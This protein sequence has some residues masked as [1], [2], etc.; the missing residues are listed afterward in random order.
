MPSGSRRSYAGYAGT[1]LFA[2]IAGALLAAAASPQDPAQ[3]RPTFRVGSSFVRVDAYPSKDGKAVPDLKAEEFEI[4][5]D[6]VPQKIESFERVEIRAGATDTEKR[7]VTS[8]RDS[9]Q[10]AANP[11]NRVFVIF[12][13]TPH[14]TLDVVRLNEALIRMLDRVLGPDDLVGVMSPKMSASQLVLGRK[15]QI[16]EQSLRSNSAFIEQLVYGKDPTEEGYEQCGDAR[17]IPRK[18]ERAT[19]EALQDLVRYLKTIR[20][21][22]KAIITVTGGWE[23]FREDR[24]ILDTKPRG[25]V[26]MDTPRTGPDGTL[27]TKPD[28]R[29]DNRGVPTRSACDADRIRL[30]TMDDEQFFR[31]L[32]ADANA[33]NASFYP[34]DPGGLGVFN[35]ALIP[36]AQ[37]KTLTGSMGVRQKRTDT[38]KTLAENTDGVALVDSNDLDG[39]L[40]RISDDLTSYYLLGYSSTNT[41]MDGR[42]R[43]LKVRVTRPGVIVRARRGYRGPT[44]EEMT[45][46]RN[47]AESMPEGTRIVTSAIGRLGSPRGDLPFRINAA[48]AIGSPALWVS[49]ELVPQP[50]RPDEFAKGGTAVVDATIG[51]VT[52][53]SEVTLKPGERTFVTQVPVARGAT[54]EISVKARITPLGGGLPFTDMLRVPSTPAPDAAQPLFFRRGVTTGNR[55]VP[56]ADLRFSRTERIRLE[57]PVAAGVA[58]KAVRVLDRVGQPLQ[59]P[60]V[61]G[62]QAP[63]TDASSA[64]RAQQTWATVELTLA[65]LS[66]ADYAI[67]VEM[68]GGQKIV[69]GLRVIR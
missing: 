53:S 30:A 16:I 43:A 59:I 21:E 4:L 69:T 49:G 36:S 17:M 15:T 55:W 66:T 29:A 27:T 8:Q 47:T 44:S 41:K 50:G 46:A 54:G 14:I 57:W 7:E 67:E 22:R 32:L 9:L 39:G 19:L 40:R 45:S 18:R 10:A 34:V 68:V 5:E 12:I 33:A 31:D 11:R 23:L 28:P 3:Q 65:P 6:G 64:A 42:F 20:E 1:G 56:A 35:N 37:E 52:V 61:I 62:S 63:G 48:T 25:I 13:D 26:G 60:A 58:V 24:S 2:A 38:L 51:A